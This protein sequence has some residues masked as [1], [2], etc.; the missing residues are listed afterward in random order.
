MTPSSTCAR[1]GLHE[2]TFL[3]CG[4]DCKFSRN[5]WHHINFT[6]LTFFSLSSAYVW[7]KT[8]S[9]GSQAFTFSI[10]V[11]WA[12]RHQN[13]VCLNNE[14]WSLYRLSFN[15]KSMVETFTS[16]FV[17]HSSSAQIDRYIRWNSDSHSCVILNV[18]G[19]CHDSTTYQTSL[20]SFRTLQ[21]SCLPNYIYD[22][23]H[24]LT[25]TLAKD[26]NFE[27]LICYSDSLHCINLIKDP[28]I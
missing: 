12:R 27:T 22:I 4:R 20:T 9:I 21:T 7:F 24:D 2:E 18:D 8:S 3:H 26:M 13:L 17:S 10:S 25:L 28:N 23:F 16:C 15:I 6:D 1:C 5:L 14:T 19:S 11:W